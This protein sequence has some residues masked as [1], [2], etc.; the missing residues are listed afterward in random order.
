MTEESLVRIRKNRKT[1][2]AALQKIHAARVVVEYS[3]SGDSGAVER[4]SI[5]DHEGKEIG[6]D[7]MVKTLVENGFYDPKKGFISKQEPVTVTLKQALENFCY[8]WIAECGNSGW[9]NNDGADGT[10]TIDVGSGGFH[11]EHNSHYTETTT[12]EHTFP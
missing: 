12:T 5:I 4:I 3:G 9:E 7:P 1:I 11:L 8:D 10:L 2:L 6:A